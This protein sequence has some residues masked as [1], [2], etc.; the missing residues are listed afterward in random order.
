MSHQHP[1][2]GPPVEPLYSPPAPAP[3]VPPVYRC[4]GCG[5][6]WVPGHELACPHGG[7]VPD[8]L[9]AV[10]TL[11]APPTVPH[12]EGDTCFEAAALTAARKV[13]IDM[14][15][16]QVAL[17]KGVHTV[18]RNGN[19]K[20][21]LISRPLTPTEMPA[22]VETAPDTLRGRD[23]QTVTGV[24]TEAI[25]QPDLPRTRKK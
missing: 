4:G 15:P 23:Q 21:E 12:H 9:T 7:T 6:L 8:G 3:T 19:G 18:V 10:P 16:E 17:A 2:Y 14:T 13:T 11:P 25:T 24:P 20:F 22:P 5:I 1:A